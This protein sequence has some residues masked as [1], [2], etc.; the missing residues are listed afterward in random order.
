MGRHLPNMLSILRILMVLPVAYLTLTD[1]PGWALFLFILAGISDGLD[2]YLAK[3][4]GWISRLGSFLDPMADKFLLVTMFIVFAIGGMLPVWLVA[5]IIARDLIILLGALAY[6]RLIGSLN[7]APLWSSKA[8]TFFQILLCVAVLTSM[9]YHGT[10][11][12]VVMP[13]LAWVVVIT[14]VFSGIEYVYSWTKIAKQELR[15]IH[16]KSYE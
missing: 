16:A 9:A 8:N 14:V 12:S 5:I 3:R 10:W 4:F 15:K 2:G 6:L 7:M 1:E 11:P 13:V